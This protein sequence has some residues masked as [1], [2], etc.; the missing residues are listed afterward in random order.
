MGLA[1]LSAA[2]CLVG[3]PLLVTACFL[4]RDPGL[5]GAGPSIFAY[6]LHRSISQ[7]IPGYVD[8]RIAS[9]VAGTLSQ[10]EITATESPVYGAFFYLL[11]TANLQAAWER[12][13]SLA[14]VSPAAAGAQAID[15]S[16]RLMLDEGHAHWVREYWGDDYLD[17]PNCFYRMLMIGSL[18]AHHELTNSTRHLSLLRRVV[19]DLAA[20]LDASPHG[21]IDDYP[22]QC[23]PCDVAVAVSMVLRADQA[24]GTN[25]KEWARAALHRMLGNFNGETPPYTADAR[26]G[27]PILAT[28]GCTNGFFFSHARDID[29]AMADE[30]Y[31]KYAADFWQE[32]SVI[33]GWREFPKW[34]VVPAYYLDPDSGPVIDG[35]GTAASGLGLGAARLH[36]DPERAGKLGAQMLASAMPMINGRLLVPWL[37]SD[38]VHAPYFAEITILHQLSLLPNQP[39]VQGPRPR[40]SLPLVVWIILLS[41]ALLFCAMFR[42]GMKL[43]LKRGR[44]RGARGSRGDVGKNG[45]SGERMD[46][47]RGAG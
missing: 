25:R 23:F 19:D 26:T 6:S 20:D 39:K 32:G 47:A 34:G 31:Q 37:V 30:L 43:L 10:F 2:L 46:R 41:G 18:T 5:R 35:F 3:Y 38:R 42:L 29:P 17:E 16:V 13:Q 24:L 21:L 7:R 12:D 1:M 36:N 28:R 9:G 8:A 4:V 44:L 14:S 22:G 40:A 45:Q 33:A 11:A 15:A 27:S